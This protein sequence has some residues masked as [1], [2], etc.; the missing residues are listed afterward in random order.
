ML[1]IGKMIRPGLLLLL[2]LVLVLPAGSTNAGQAPA[3]QSAN[4]DCSASPIRPGCGMVRLN[5]ASEDQRTALAEQGIEIYARLFSPEGEELLYL[6]LPAAERLR[7]SDFPELRTAQLETLDD[8]SRPGN[9]YLGWIAEE[10]SLEA[11]RETAVV[12]DVLGEQAVILAT[13]AQEVALH[14]AGVH[15]APLVLHRLVEY[16]HTPAAPQIDMP[17][18]FVTNFMNQVTQTNVINHVRRLSGEVPVTTGGGTYTLGTRFTPNEQAITRATRYVYETMASY[19]LDTTYHYYNLFYNGVD[20]GDRRSVVAEQRGVLYPDQILFMTAHMDSRSETYATSYSIA[21]GADDNASGTT[22]VL[23]AAEI[24]SQYTFAYTIRYILFTGE[25]QLFKGSAPYAAEVAARNEQVLGVLNLDMIGSNTGGIEEFELHVRPGETGDLAIA[26]TFDQVAD[27]YNLLI[28]PRILFDGLNFSD[29]SSFWTY[30]YPAILAM[31]DYISPHWHKQTD[32]VNNLDHAYFTAAVKGA[33]GTVAHLA[34]F[35]SPN[36]SG[37]VTHSGSLEPVEGA[38]VT[39]ENTSYRETF[40]AD[41]QGHFAGMLPAGSYL[42]GVSAPGY[43]SYDQANVVL[44]DPLAGGGVNLEVDLCQLVAQV[45]WA[46]SPIPPQPNAPVTLSAQYSA[47]TPPF[48]YAWTVDGAAAG[49]DPVIM[50]TFTTDG[51]HLVELEVENACS[52]QVG[53][54]GLAVGGEVWYLPVV[55]RTASLPLP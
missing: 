32:T 49:T 36:V 16:A 9:Y 40:T 8:G 55:G 45:R 25:E 28:Q 30:D 50:Q 19:G 4:Q 14:D 2:V 35:Y 44:P 3:A 52:V 27:V 37:S 10:G 38:L 31:E 46:A 20:Y 5:V 33:V 21:P 1:E 7:S 53:S 26:Q 42:L 11:A 29:H 43:A 15:S 24:L 41:E 6:P 17:D 13:E 48:T 18:P 51:V 47:G 22:A 34:G 54:Y 12:L 39:L 23:T